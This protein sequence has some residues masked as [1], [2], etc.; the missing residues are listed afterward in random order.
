MRIQFIRIHS[1]MRNIISELIL[2]RIIGTWK[3][4]V[5]NKI[6]TP[7]TSLSPDLDVEKVVTDASPKGAIWVHHDAVDSKYNL[8]DPSNIVGESG[9][10]FWDFIHIH[11]S[12]QFKRWWQENSFIDHYVTP[13]IVTFLK[14]TKWGAPGVKQT[15][16]A[17]VSRPEITEHVSADYVYQFPEVM[18][19]DFVQITLSQEESMLSN[20]GAD[21]FL[22][23]TQTGTSFRILCWQT[24][25]W[26]YEI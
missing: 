25:N 17:A 18:T 21:G 15:Y 26:K 22:G 3:D 20:L 4:G 11:S 1:M 16:D 23:L 8:I 5:G 13:K 10:T 12:N 14:A 7:T 24:I 2:E 19:R 9:K 6:F